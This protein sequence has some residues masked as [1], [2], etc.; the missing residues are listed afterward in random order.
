MNQLIASFSTPDWIQ[1]YA[2]VF[3]AI[4]LVVTL[5][6]QWKTS[7]DQEKLLSME[8]EKSRR[9]IMP[10]FKVDLRCFA[11][12]TFASYTIA[13]QLT[14]NPARSVTFKSVNVLDFDLE[15]KRLM[16]VGEEQRFELGRN[17]I[18]DTP[19]HLELIKVEFIDEELREYS[20]TITALR[21]ELYISYP[22]QTH[23]VNGR[24]YHRAIKTIKRAFPL[25][26]G[27]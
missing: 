21:G 7:S 25:Q 2:S 14:R 8:M 20:Q 13:I 18:Q 3:A 27:S 22:L 12:D 26:K 4:G 16:D 9:A 10:F 19:R 24:W 11:I 1:A 5:I 6:L 23:D 15:F 17:P